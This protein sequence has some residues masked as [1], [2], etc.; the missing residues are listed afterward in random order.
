MRFKPDIACF[1][2]LY[3]NSPTCQQCGFKEE[4]MKKMEVRNEHQKIL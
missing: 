3:D 2:K 4:C 1:G